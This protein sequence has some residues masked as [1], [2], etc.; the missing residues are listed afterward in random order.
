MAARLERKFR[1][2]GISGGWIE[3]F[4]SALDLSLRE[5]VEDFEGLGDRGVMF[6]ERETWEIKALVGVLLHSWVSWIG[7]TLGYF[8]TAL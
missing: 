7:I 1:I 5:M 3:R 2:R 8:I 6:N 4:C